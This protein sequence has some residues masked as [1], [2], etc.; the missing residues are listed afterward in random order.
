MF[1]SAVATLEFSGEAICDLHLKT[2]YIAGQSPRYTR[3][4]GVIPKSIVPQIFSPIF[5]NYSTVPQNQ[6]LGFVFL[7]GLLPSPV[8]HISE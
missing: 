1:Y 4:D 5:F 2:I 3:L 8:S 7:R 6:R